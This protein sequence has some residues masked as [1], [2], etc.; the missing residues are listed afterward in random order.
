MSVIEIQGGGDRRSM[1]KRYERK[2]KHDAVRELV[3]LVHCCWNRIDQLEALVPGAAELPDCTGRSPKD[4]AIEHAEYMAKCV[5]R[6]SGC[7]DEYGTAIAAAELADDED[8]GAQEAVEE[9]RGA[10]QEALVDL[11]GYV[12]EFRKRSARAIAAAKSV[13]EQGAVA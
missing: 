1:I 6:L 8:D 2:S 3:D 5:D 11:R 10:L 7:F 9:T 12:Y 13:K 4:Y